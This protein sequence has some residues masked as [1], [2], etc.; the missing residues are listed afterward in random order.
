MNR[1]PV[2]VQHR[3]GTQAHTPSLPSQQHVSAG[4][5]LDRYQPS[6]QTLPLIGKL[7]N[8]YDYPSGSA[9]EES[10]VHKHH[11]KLLDPLVTVLI[12]LIIY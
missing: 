3:E 11:N 8:G 6:D 1:S 12:L 4:L 7:N 9:V 5:S 2:V 10:A